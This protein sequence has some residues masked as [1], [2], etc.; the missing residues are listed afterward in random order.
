MSSV[1]FG[2]FASRSTGQ[3]VSPASVGRD[4]DIVIHKKSVTFQTVLLSGKNP[5]RFA[6]L[7]PNNVGFDELFYAFYHEVS[8]DKMFKVMENQNPVLLTYRDVGP[9]ITNPFYV[10]VAGMINEAVFY[11]IIYTPVR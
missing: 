9:L 11:E 10:N 8:S 7:L 6:W 5:N 1:N 3:P 2:Q 4:F